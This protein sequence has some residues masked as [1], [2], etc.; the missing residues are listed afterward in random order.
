MGR[1]IGIIGKKRTGKDTIGDYLVNN[2]NFI[3]YSFADPLK[4]G[5]MEIFGLTENQVFGDDKDKIV[6]EW[7][8][9]PRVLLQIMGTE[10]FQYDIQRHIPEFKK[11]GREI[12]VKRFL[13]WHKENKDRNIVICDVRFKHEAEAIIKQGGEI[14]K[15]VRDTNKYTIDSHASEMELEEIQ[16]LNAII[17]NNS[18]LDKLY[19]NINKSLSELLTHAKGDG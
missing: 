17:H 14:W 3:K 11:I 15:V 18:S 8:I 5:A 13:Q 12:W 6:T 4:R 1:L 7:G 16:D 9:T 19:S 2:H 10:L